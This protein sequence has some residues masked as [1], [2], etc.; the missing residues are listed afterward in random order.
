MSDRL[1]RVLPPYE[2]LDAHPEFSIFE[3]SFSIRR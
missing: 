1:K 3:D 2:F